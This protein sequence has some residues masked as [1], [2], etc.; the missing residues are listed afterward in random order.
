MSFLEWL[1]PGSTRSS[2][3]LAIKIR[4]SPKYLLSQID[5]FDPAPARPVGSRVHQGVYDLLGKAPGQI[6][7][8]IVETGHGEHARRRV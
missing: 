1:C 3:H 4:M 6:V 7:D 5:L 2:G 8:A